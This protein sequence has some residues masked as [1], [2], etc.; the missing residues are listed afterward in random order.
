MDDLAVRCFAGRVAPLQYVAHVVV[1][2]LAP[3]D[4]DFLLDDARGDIAA[5]QVD[6]GAPDRLTGHLLGGVDSTADRMGGG[7][8]IDDRRAL[9]AARDLVTSAEDSRVLLGPG[10]EAAGFG[11]ADVD[12]RADAAA[13]AQA[14]LWALPWVLP[15]VLIGG[16]GCVGCGDIAA[17]AAGAG[18]NR[19]FAPPHVLLP[20][21][22][23]FFAG[24]ASLGSGAA[25]RTAGRAA[26]CRRSDISLQDAA[27]PLRRRKT[28]PTQRR[29]F[30]GQQ[31]VDRVVD[32][33][34]PAPRVDPDRGADPPDEIGLARQ[35]VEER[36]G[37]AR[38]V[39]ADD[40][41]QPRQTGSNP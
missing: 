14:L 5:R 9:D 25:A 24:P 20:D 11:G 15:W 21:G 3:P 40:A 18:A 34:V 35:H 37:V 32:A 39:V 26:A 6:H 19:L 28:T 7:V 41:R 27:R 29:G 16:R 1:G 36:G 17:V 38:G 10:D 2:D 8:E 4:A 13:R 30:L 22:R 23:G 31:H 33:Q 12:R